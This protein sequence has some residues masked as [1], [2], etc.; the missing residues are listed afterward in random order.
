VA[1]RHNTCV[2]PA[3][4]NDNAGWTSNGAAPTRTDVTGLGFAR[5]FAAKFED[6]SV[7]FSP[8]GAATAG[9]TYTVSMYVRPTVF[10]ISGSIFIE[11]L[12][13]G[14]S[15]LG[16]SSSAFTA[17]ANTV[18]RISQTDTAP[19]N[20]A[21][22]RIVITGENY[23]SNPTY[24][25]MCLLEQATLDDYFDGASPGASWDGTAGNSAS[26]FS[27]TQN[28]SGTGTITSTA[29]LTA[30][31]TKSANGTGSI[32]SAATL[33]STGTAGRRGTGAIAATATLSSTG[34]AAR[35][36]TGALAAAASLTASGVKHASGTGS[37]S[38]IATLTGGPPTGRPGTLT[39]S[40]TPSA[41]LTPSSSAP[42]L[43]ATSSP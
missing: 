39:L 28:L 13:G 41:T 40:G 5:Q 20:T 43:T 30:S 38:V 36:G 31:G 8:G 10:Q 11:F 7:A 33:S 34:T 4:H 29:T 2:N 16:F 24:Y 42:A 6:G 15:S 27:G 22:V 21:T 12:N 35:A 14:G 18:T 17:N 9:L 25:T 26:T 32:T 1:D 19:T 3:L 37:I 23:V